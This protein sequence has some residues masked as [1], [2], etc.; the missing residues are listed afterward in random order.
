MFSNFTLQLHL[1]K[2]TLVKFWCS[3]K[4]K[5]TI[6]DYLK[7]LLKSILHPTT[8]VDFL[9]NFNKTNIAVPNC[10]AVMRI[11]LS[12]IKGDITESCKNKKYVRLFTIFILK[13]IFVIKILDLSLLF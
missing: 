11:Q 8:Y 6:H 1:N 5:K 9:N 7:R 2:L 10:R 3:I 4:E 13:N 12:S